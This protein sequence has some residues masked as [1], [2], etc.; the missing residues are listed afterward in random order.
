MRLFIGNLNFKTT[1]E[2][3]RELLKE[4]GEVNSLKIITDRD[5]G[6]SKGFAFVEMATDEQAKSVMENLNGA[7]FDGKV[8]NVDYAREKEESE[9]RPRSGFKRKQKTY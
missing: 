4:Y 8:L 7:E 3:L 5:T 2:N 9:R 6:R 1:E